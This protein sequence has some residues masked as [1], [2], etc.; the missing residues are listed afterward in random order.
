M[1]TTVE[2][3]ARCTTSVPVLINHI[4]LPDTDGDY[5]YRSVFR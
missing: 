5:A 4:Q 1:Q 3:N 2:R